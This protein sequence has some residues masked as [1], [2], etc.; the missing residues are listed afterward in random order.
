MTPIQP[1]GSLRGCVHCGLVQRLP[2]GDVPDGHEARCAR[3]GRVVRRAHG[4]AGT[5]RLCTAWALAALLCYPFGVGLPVMRLRQLGHTH[6]A[7]IWSGTVSLLS[8]GQVVVGLV[9]LV[10]SL[11]LPI[12]KLVG[13]FVLTRWPSLLGR[14]HQAG[15][16]RWI[17]IAGRWGMVD[18]LL[19]AVLV[20]ALKLGD[21]VAVTPG[22]G[23]TAF[24]ASV[25]LS[26]LAS[27]SFDPQAIWEGSDDR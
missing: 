21:L 24:G 20:A 10:C 9:V 11:I 22:P 1:N 14:H 12:F 25:V 16:Y 27:V 8:H 23:A 15:V 18:V 19:V 4:F 2:S 7:S 5:N 26:L 6:E 17:E 13:L 3:C